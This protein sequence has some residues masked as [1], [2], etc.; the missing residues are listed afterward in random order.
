MK[1][2]FQWIVVALF[3][4][5]MGCASTGAHHPDGHSHEDGQVASH[6]H[7]DQAPGDCCGSCGGAEKSEKKDKGSCCGSCGG[8]AP[9]KE[10]EKE[11]DG[12]KT[13][14]NS[15]SDDGKKAEAEAPPEK[16][17][18]CGSCGG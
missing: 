13:D 6:S 14:K 4:T 9:K 12:T 18:C 1:T 17:S 10:K 16:S 7:G 15:D 2:I 8:D 3:L 11:C 5:T